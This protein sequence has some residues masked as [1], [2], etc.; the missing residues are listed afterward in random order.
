MRNGN[1]HI[2]GPRV[3][4]GKGICVRDGSGNPFCD[5]GAK[6][7]QRTA[8]RRHRLVLET[9]VPSAGTPKTAIRYKQKTQSCDWVSL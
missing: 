5:A 6:R 4:C 8:R 9:F 7:L 3:D 2:V 1:H